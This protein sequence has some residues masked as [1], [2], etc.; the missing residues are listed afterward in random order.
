MFYLIVKIQSVFSLAAF[1]KKNSLTF[2]WLLMWNIMV[3]M[4]LFL[5]KASQIK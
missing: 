3:E 1:D 2:L 5:M 4:C